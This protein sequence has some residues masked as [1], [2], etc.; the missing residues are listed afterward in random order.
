MVLSHLTGFDFFLLIVIV[1]SIVW[2]SMRGFLREIISLVTWFA[3]FCVALVFTGTVA[4]TVS[5]YTKTQLLATLVSFLILFVVTL[6]FGMVINFA[7]SHLAE[8]TGT[9]VANRLLGGGFG[10]GRGIL[11]T[12]LIVFL[13][14]N[15]IWDSSSWFKDSSLVGQL[16]GVSGLMQD[17]LRIVKKTTDKIVN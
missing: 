17:Q 15:T 6:I 2:G 12:L 7:V 14:S 9:A 4:V 5:Q 3:A 10:F 8:N 11:V 16:Q 1:L 13:I